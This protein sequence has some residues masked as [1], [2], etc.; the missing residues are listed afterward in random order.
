[1]KTA[2]VRNSVFE[3]L[4]VPA[5]PKTPPAAISMNYNMAPDDREPRAPILV[6]DFNKKAGDDFKVYY[7]LQAPLTVA[8]CNDSRPAL[9]GWVCK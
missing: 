2:V 7:S 1:M 5:I 8:P 4:N 9:D 3:P 6:Y